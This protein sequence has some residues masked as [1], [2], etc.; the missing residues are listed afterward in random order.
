MT[1]LSRIGLAVVM[2]GALYA[3][4]DAR[5]QA[6]FRSETN[7]IEVVASVTDKDGKFVQGLT[8]ADF[9]IKEQGRRE[10]VDHLSFVEVPRAGGRASL[11]AAYRAD[12]PAEMRDADGRVY[13]IYLNGATPANTPLVRQLA[14]Q[15]V[16]DHVMP[17]DRVAVWD[18]QYPLRDVTFTDDKVKLLADIA[19]YTGVGSSEGD[20]PFA[21][22]CFP[23]SSSGLPSGV[24]E[25]CQAALQEPHSQ[26]TK[27]INWFNSIQ[28]RRKSIVLF[29]GG[30]NGP[31]EPVSRADITLYAVDVRGLVATDASIL[32][33]GLVGPAQAAAV[34]SKMSAL[35]QSVDGLLT[36]AQRTGGFA[37]INRNEFSQGFSRIVDANSQYYVLGYA[38]S[39]TRR[40]RVYRELDVKVTRPGLKVQARRGYY[41]RF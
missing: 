28:G 39:Y 29:A 32:G 36:L 10:S 33:G 14:T 8:A 18:S 38:S 22:R 7:Y 2:A 30:W 15:F 4:V 31:T 20:L 16:N 27:A 21:F 5:Q 37:M 11:P 23:G 25:Q 34:N 19:P 40:D 9:E 41:P 12:L 6:V 3:A 13:L 35:N 26:L 24:R 1:A 17:G